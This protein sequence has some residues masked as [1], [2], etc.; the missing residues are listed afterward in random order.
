MDLA[1]PSGPSR[2]SVSARVI[3]SSGL[4][5]M[6]LSQDVGL[7]VPKLGTSVANWDGL[8]T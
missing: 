2:G 6:R 1:E 4:P 3:S 5:G 8:V 7:S